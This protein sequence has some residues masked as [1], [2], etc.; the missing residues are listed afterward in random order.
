M[1]GMNLNGALS[2]MAHASHGPER[3][4]L[5]AAQQNGGMRA[6]LAARDTKFLPEP[7]GPKSERR[8]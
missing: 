6:F 3:D 4:A 2:A 7:F 1:S 5:F 8:A